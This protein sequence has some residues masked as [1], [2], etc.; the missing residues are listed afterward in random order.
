MFD[1]QV[2]LAIRADHARSNHNVLL[3][4]QPLFANGAD[5]EFD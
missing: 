5:R 3:Q 1:P 4:P 2:A